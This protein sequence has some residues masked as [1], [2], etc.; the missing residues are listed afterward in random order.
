[1]LT[2]TSLRE[3][4]RGLRRDE[5]DSATSLFYFFLIIMLTI[6]TTD[7]PLAKFPDYTDLLD[8][9]DSTMT[10]NGVVN[11]LVTRVSDEP[12]RQPSPQPTHFSVP[13]KLNGNGHRILRKATV[14]YV[15][16]EFEGK[17]EQMKQGR[18]HFPWSHGHFLTYPSESN[19]GPRWLDSRLAC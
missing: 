3:P 18:L 15:A 5:H 11:K 4:P 2:Y 9:V 7:L 19:S 16:P 1:M 17:V 14:G 10:T 6:Q 13:Q 8:S 12:S